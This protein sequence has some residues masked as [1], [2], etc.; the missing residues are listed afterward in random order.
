[1]LTRP[2]PHPRFRSSKKCSA[3]SRSSRREY[4]SRRRWR[5]AAPTLR[6]TPCSWCVLAA[7]R[8]RRPP[9]PLLPLLRRRRRRRR[10]RVRTCS[11]PTPSFCVM[12]AVFFPR[13]QGQG[14]HHCLFQRGVQEAEPE[15]DVQRG[16]RRRGGRRGRWAGSREGARPRPRQ[17]VETRPF[18]QRSIAPQRPGRATRARLRYC[19]TRYY[20]GREG[21]ESEGRLTRR[22]NIMETQRHSVKN[23]V[24]TPQHRDQYNKT[25]TAT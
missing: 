18:R 12:C 23:T 17:E 10:L 21:S 1:M 2:R 20:S 19:A 7:A 15:Q 3:R 8:R 22:G 9:L 11:P 16:R 25:T 14:G 13:G 24:L 4:T 5:A 6:T